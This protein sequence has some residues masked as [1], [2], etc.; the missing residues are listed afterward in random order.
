MSFLFVTGQSTSARSS[1]A[2]MLAKAI[3]RVTQTRRSATDTDWPQ[4]HYSQAAPAWSASK[5]YHEHYQP[6]WFTQLPRKV[7]GRPLLPSQR[8]NKQHTRFRFFPTRHPNHPSQQHLKSFGEMLKICSGCFVTGPSS[9]SPGQV[10]GTALAHMYLCRIKA[11]KRF[12]FQ[13]KSS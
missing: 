13:W 1:S 5:S 10:R 4:H 3:A 8:K 7:M 12:H 6:L 2:R 9:T 11:L